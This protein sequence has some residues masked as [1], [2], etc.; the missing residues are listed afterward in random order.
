M[1]TEV[2]EVQ[3][4]NAQHSI[5][6]TESEMTRDLSD[7][8]LLKVYCRIDDKE[9]GRT[10]FAKDEQLENTPASSPNVG[11]EFGMTMDSNPEFEKHLYPIDESDFGRAML[12]RDLQL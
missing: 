3:L 2:K 11:T 9:L 8:Q 6:L 4:L 5:L 7:L 1:F 12:R 10:T